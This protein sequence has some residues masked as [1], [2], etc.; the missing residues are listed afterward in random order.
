MQTRQR[1]FR[2]LES[3]WKRREW[4]SGCTSSHLSSVGGDDQA[5]VYDRIQIEARVQGALEEQ[6]VR[7][8]ND[9]GLCACDGHFCDNALCPCGNRR[10]VC[11]IDN[12]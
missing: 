5:D 7:L 3:V 1:M 11:V 4:V 9:C 12:R 8:K 6:G 10:N 2:W